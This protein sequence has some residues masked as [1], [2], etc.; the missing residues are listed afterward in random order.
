MVSLRKTWQKKSLNERGINKHRYW[1]Q[2]ELIIILC[3][4][5]F[6]QKKIKKVVSPTGRRH[7]SPNL[8]PGFWDHHTTDTTQVLAL[9]VTTTWF[10]VQNVP[11]SMFPGREVWADRFRAFEWSK[12]V[13]KWLRR[14]NSNWF[15]YWLL[16]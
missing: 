1:S 4:Q 3:C 6:L 2:A 12:N 14:Q 10:H 16:G 5:L 15:D 7:E 9:M 8:K 13:H 11:C